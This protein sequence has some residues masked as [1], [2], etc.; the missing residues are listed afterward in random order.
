M[1]KGQKLSCECDSEPSVW[2]GI[3]YEEELL[4]CEKIGLYSKFTSEGWVKCLPS[5][6]GA[7]HDLNAACMILIRQAAAEAEDKK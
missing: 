2:K 7:V 6:G 1:C 3:R 5:E 4:L